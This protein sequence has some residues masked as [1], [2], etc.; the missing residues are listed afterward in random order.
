MSKPETGPKGW[1]KLFLI[2]V[3]LGG[4]LAFLLGLHLVLCD[5][6][7]KFKWAFIV[8][9][10][11]MTVTALQDWKMFARREAEALS[12][13]RYCIVMYLILSIVFIF[14]DHAHV[15]AIFQILAFLVALGWGALW[16][17]FLSKSNQVKSLTS[18]RRVCSKFALVA[19]VLVA[20]TCIAD[21]VINAVELRNFYKELRGSNLEGNT[22]SVDS[23]AS[24]IEVNE[25]IKTFFFSFDV[26]EGCY[27]YEDESYEW[28]TN[29]ED[30]FIYMCNVLPL[31]ADTRVGDSRIRLAYKYDATDS[32]F[33]N[34][35][36]D[37]CDVTVYTMKYEKEGEQFYAIAGLKYSADYKSAVLIEAHLPVNDIDIFDFVVNSIG[38]D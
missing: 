5:S 14:G 29:L 8:G 31:A 3:C 19:S 23:S 12:A 17:I 7:V 26:P 32:K 15:S 24:T 9:G 11:A 35:K 22:E 18:G 34:F 38:F 36:Q 20:L 27:Y 16:W 13:A 21:M 30:V 6:M 4:F 10:I 28:V 1:L 2:L 33:A 25:R 37:G